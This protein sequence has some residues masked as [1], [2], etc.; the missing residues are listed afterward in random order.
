MN[1]SAWII[2]EIIFPQDY[3]QVA[4]LW[5]TVGGGVKFGKSDTET[6]IRKKLQ[7][8]PDLFLV[9]ES[10]DRIIG[11]VL[12]GFDGRRG[13]IYHLAVAE[14]YRKRGIGQALMN[15]IE[16]RITAK[17]AYKIYLMM[18]KNYPELVEFYT[19]LGW[20]MMDVVTAGKEFYPK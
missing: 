11:T 12:G 18:D 19:K 16:N 6:E 2:R 5:Q 8:D 20:T 14:N 3:P 9:C 4:E 13:M 10:E 1:S 7:R 15:E 17:G